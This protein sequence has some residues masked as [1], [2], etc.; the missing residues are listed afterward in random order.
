MENGFFIEIGANDPVIN[1]N[2]YF[3]E[4]QGWLGIGID[5]ISRFET[6]WQENRKSHFFCGAVAEKSMTID[7]VE[8]LSKQGWEHAL[9]GFKQHVR[10]E[11]MS[12]YDHIEYKVQAKPLDDYLKNIPRVNVIM[13]DVE[14]AEIQVL[15]GINFEQL[16]PDLVLIEN[17]KTYGGCNQV[18]EYMQKN[19]YHCHARIAATDDVFLKNDFTLLNNKSKKA[20]AVN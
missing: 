9:S 14:G 4:Q 11:D 12:M 1:N 20:N 19:G 5:P 2:S 17:I 6:L 7:F 3:L 10:E 15:Q 18:R 16:K 8:I 13:I